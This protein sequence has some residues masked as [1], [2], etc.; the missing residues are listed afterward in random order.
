MTTTTV[1]EHA[2]EGTATLRRILIAEDEHLIASELA[3][4]LNSIGCEVTGTATTGEQAVEMAQADRPD[5]ALMDIRMP[6]L[7]GLVASRQLYEE[8]GIPVVVISAYSAQEDLDE[9]AD[10]GVFG[11]LL[12]PV[13]ADTLRTALRIA[14]AKHQ[15]QLEL[16]DKVGELELTLNNRKVIERAKGILM[17]QLSL[18]EDQAYSRLRKSARDKRIKMAELAT[19]IL[20]ANHLLHE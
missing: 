20:E 3:E 11:Y 18:T 15:Q 2:E 19:A 10:I 12:K 5:L 8:L 17:Q 1:R 9:A 16:A 7:N 14:W 6:G 4:Q 13:T